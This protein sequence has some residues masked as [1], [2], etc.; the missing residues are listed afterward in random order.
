MTR[1]YR[2]KTGTVVHRPDC[3][4]LGKAVPWRWAEGKS[5]GLIAMH[6]AEKGVV[7]CKLCAPPLWPTRVNMRLVSGD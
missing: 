6:M 4:R 1:Y 5:D 7:P 3:T 2:S